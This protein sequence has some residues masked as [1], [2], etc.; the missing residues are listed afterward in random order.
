M[1]KKIFELKPI[2]QRKSVSVKESNDVYTP[3]LAHYKSKSI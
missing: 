1:I 3:Q 2:E